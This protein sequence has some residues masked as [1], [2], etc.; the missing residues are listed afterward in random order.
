MTRHFRSRSALVL[1]AGLA[2]IALASAVTAIA[3]SGSARASGGP[4]DAVDV[5]YDRIAGTT[6]SNTWA[7]LVTGV[8]TV[9]EDDSPMLLVRYTADA[10]CFASCQVRLRLGRWVEDGANSRFDYSIVG[11]AKIA[12]PPARHQYAAESAEFLVARLEPGRY[13]LTV[14]GRTTSSENA[15]F[16]RQLLVV[17][18]I[19][20]ATTSAPR[21]RPIVETRAATAGPFDSSEVYG[22]WRTVA[23]TSVVVPAGQRN[24][25]LA[26]FSAASNCVKA[27]ILAIGAPEP[28]QARIRVRKLVAAGT[29]D[30]PSYPDALV[31]FDATGGQTFRAQ[32]A[33]TVASPVGPGTYQIEVRVNETHSW[34]LRS[35]LLVV[36][37]VNLVVGDGLAVAS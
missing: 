28:C 6:T 7:N 34:R 12:E 36:D 26:R 30:V 5:V 29:E 8:F 20:T 19:R 25:L 16:W 10:G 17:E 22:R 27:D 9:A 23:S 21:P 4:I 24:L 11:L 15:T 33:E 2:A 35:P 1:T 18:Q 37:R 31:R 32:R 3:A 14:Q 13:S